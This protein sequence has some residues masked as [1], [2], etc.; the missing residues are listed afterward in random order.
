MV[1]PSNL[2]SPTLVSRIQ[3]PPP[4]LSLYYCI[5]PP[6]DPLTLEEVIEV[7]EAELGDGPRVIYRDPPP[8]LPILG[9]LVPTSYIKY[10]PGCH[11]LSPR[12]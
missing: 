9:E 3:D 11:D 2:P 10:K 7:C 12:L 6:T 8:P 4:P 1:P 5:S